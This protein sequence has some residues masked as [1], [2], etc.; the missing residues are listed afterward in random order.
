MSRPSRVDVGGYV[1]HTLN[2]ASAWV[3]LF[4]KE[5][6]YQQFEQVLHEA[7]ARTGMRIL[8]YCLMRNH[9]HLVLWPETDGALGRFITWLTLTHTQRWHAR[10]GSAGAGHLYQGRYKSFLVQAD[11]HLL[12]VCRYVERNPLRAGLVRRPEAWRWGSL[13]RRERGHGLE[14]LSDWP[15]ACPDDWLQFVNRAGAAAEARDAARFGT[16]WAAVRRALLGRRGW[17]GSSISAPPCAPAAARSRQLVPDASSLAPGPR[18]RSTRRGG[19]GCGRGRR[20]AC[21][22][23]ARGRAPSACAASATGPLPQR[24]PRPSAISASVSGSG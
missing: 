3:G 2:R 23:G 19:S 4:E 8:A 10:R 22:P 9:W 17:C 18:V 6:D 12:A 1:Y 11:E 5:D 21:A 7:Q 20:A 13:W 14:L 24:L 16:A 15:I